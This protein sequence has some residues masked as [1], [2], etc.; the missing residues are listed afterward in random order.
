MIFIDI[1]QQLFAVEYIGT[2]VALIANQT[3]GVIHIGINHLHLQ[4]CTHLS[5]ICPCWTSALRAGGNIFTGFFN[6][7]MRTIRAQS[8]LCCLRRRQINLIDCQLSAVN[9][10]AVIRCK[11]TDS[12]GS[13]PAVLIDHL[14]VFLFACRRSCGGLLIFLTVQHGTEN[15]S[16]FRECVVRKQ[17]FVREKVENILF[18]KFLKNVQKCSFFTLQVLDFL[19]I[20]R[21]FG[22]RLQ[23]LDHRFERVHALTQSVPLLLEIKESVQNLNLHRAVLGAFSASKYLEFFSGT[24]I[25]VGSKHL[26]KGVELPRQCTP[27]IIQEIKREHIVR[28]LIQF[29]QNNTNLVRNRPLRNALLHPGIHAERNK[30]SLQN[31]RSPKKNARRRNITRD[32]IQRIRIEIKIMRSCVCN[33]QSQRISVFTTGTTGTL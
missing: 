25:K 4:H 17:T 3:L 1:N 6:L 30:L 29:V 15:D 16:G 22:L 14:L 19:V 9:I 26:H 5:L 32:H 31:S 8:P 2:I 28:T 11:F 27:D 10:E 23:F 7:R 13:R 33:S 20:G 24:I 12:R 18:A 21:V